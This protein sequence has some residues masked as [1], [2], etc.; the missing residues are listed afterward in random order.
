MRRRGREGQEDGL[1]TH[2]PPPPTRST[3]TVPHHLR[4]PA[5]LTADVRTQNRR[6]RG[7]AEDG[8]RSEPGG[9]AAETFLDPEDQGLVSS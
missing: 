4:S 1:E 2:G 7:G 3:G 8:R 5:V 9:S 6:Q